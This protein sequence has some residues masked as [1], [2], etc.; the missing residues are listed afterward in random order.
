M[1]GGPGSWWRPDSN[2]RSPSA[3]Q[4]GAVTDRTRQHRPVRSDFD[5]SA[6]RCQRKENL[7]LSVNGP[8]WRW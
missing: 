1:G 2:W 4:A 8:H 6:L 7:T 3:A 5:V